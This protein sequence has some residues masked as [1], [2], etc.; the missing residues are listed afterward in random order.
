MQNYGQVEK[1]TYGDLKKQTYGL[2]TN[3]QTYIKSDIN[4]KSIVIVDFIKNFERAKEVFLSA[5]LKSSSSVI[6]DAISAFVVIASSTITNKSIV[7]VDSI[8]NIIKPI[9][10]NIKSTGI[11]DVNAIVKSFYYVKANIKSKLNLKLSIKCINYSNDKGVKITQVIS[12]T[13]N[14]LNQIVNFSELQGK[15]YAELNGI[16]YVKLEYRKRPNFD[17]KTKLI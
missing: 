7:K 8:K 9:V 3:G 6:V 2:I 15:K 1:F 11:V 10:I 4:S 16:Q 14:F 17:V 13:V 5:N 12:K